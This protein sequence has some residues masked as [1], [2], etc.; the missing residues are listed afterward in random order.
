VRLFYVSVWGEDNNRA[1]K[2]TPLTF[3]WTITNEYELGIIG[4]HF[5]G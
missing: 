5:P 2:V 4:A 3:N 1:E